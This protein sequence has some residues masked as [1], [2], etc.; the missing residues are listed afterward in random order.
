MN[1]ISDANS[2]MTVN[3]FCERLQIST[4]TAYRMIK[5]QQIP[6]IKFGRRC[7][8]FIHTK[9][10]WVTNWVTPE[11]PAAFPPPAK[12]KKNRKPFQIKVSGAPV[13]SRYDRI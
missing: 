2:H 7:V 6:A 12:T 1:Q 9:E 8:R 10:C 13:K 11:N 3:E 4:S 5:R